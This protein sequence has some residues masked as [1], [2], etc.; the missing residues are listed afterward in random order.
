MFNA[1]MIC[2]AS[3]LL[4]GAVAPAVSDDDNAVVGTVQETGWGKFKIKDENGTVRLFHISKKATAFSPEDWRPMIGDK[5]SIKYSTFQRRNT[6]VAQID[7]VKLIE[8]GPNTPRMTSPVDVEIREMGRGS[9]RV[10]IL[11]SGKLVK[12]S[13]GRATRMEPAGWVPTA[14]EKARITFSFRTG[15][16]FGVTYIADMIAKVKEKE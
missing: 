8:A 6:T 3:A 1:R 12:F 16:F 15:M 7:T 14:G 5:V 9:V 13:R 10:K 11:K 4:I 2:L